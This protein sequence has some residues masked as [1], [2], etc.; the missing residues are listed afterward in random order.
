MLTLEQ[1]AILQSKRANAKTDYEYQLFD[2]LI[3]LELDMPETA[4]E[5]LQLALATAT[6]ELESV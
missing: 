5:T 1:F 3:S 4:F 6:T 2:A